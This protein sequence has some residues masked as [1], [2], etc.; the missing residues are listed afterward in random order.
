L[1]GVGILIDMKIYSFLRSLIFILIAVLGL[2]LSVIIVALSVI[3]F[4][5]ARAKQL[6]T[7]SQEKQQPTNETINSNKQLHC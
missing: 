7:S 6:I 2:S 5:F 1:V 4:L 3:I